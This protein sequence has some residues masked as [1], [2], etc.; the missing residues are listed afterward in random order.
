[1][2]CNVCFITDSFALD[3]PV[4]QITES[5]AE[6]SALI[7][8]MS[9][10]FI[11]FSKACDFDE[12]IAMA[13]ASRNLNE[14]G[15]LYSAAYDG[16]MSSPSKLEL[17]SQHLTNI[18]NNTPPVLADR[19]VGLYSEN[20]DKQLSLQSNKTIYNEFSLVS[21]CSE[22]IVNYR[23]SH[24]DY[25]IA[26]DNVYKNLIFRTD[27]DGESLL[28]NKLNKMDGDY[29]NFALGMVTCLKFMNSYKVLPDDSLNNIEQINGSLNVPVTPEG[30]GKGHRDNNELKRDFYINKKKYANINCEF[31]CKLQYPDGAPSNGKPKPNRIYFGFIEPTKSVH[32]IAIAHIGDHW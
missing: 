3:L 12:F 2:K 9:T 1:M 23:R 30:R 17:D 14:M 22:I 29:R 27:I 25:A 28:F 6:A 21:Y 16:N 5:F 20:I 32:K 19:W 15:H 26:F 10:D 7:A 31:H 18:T 13:I 11:E 8:K 24:E 4:E